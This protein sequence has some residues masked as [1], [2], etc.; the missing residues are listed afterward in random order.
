MFFAK[1]SPVLLTVGFI[2]VVMWTWAPPEAPC[3]PRRTCNGPYRSSA[4][5]WSAP[6][7]ERPHFSTWSS[8][9]QSCKWKRHRHLLG[10][11]KL[12]MEQREGESQGSVS[13]SRNYGKCNLS[14]YYHPTTNL[15]EGYVLSRVCLSVCPQW[16]SH[17][18]IHEPVQTCSLEDPRPWPCPQN[19]SLRIP[20]RPI[21]TC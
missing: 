5:P 14:V 18:T 11:R 10:V 16:E 21:Q 4:S 20:P 6:R 7:R 13:Q 12:T 1:T 15:R 8:R 19:C 3:R 9:K 2:S 17:V